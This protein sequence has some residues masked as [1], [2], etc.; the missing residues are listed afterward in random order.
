MMEKILI[1]GAKGFFGTRFCKHYQG[2]YEI[3]GTDKDDTDITDEKAVSQLISQIK[4][5]YI[6]HTAAVP[7]TNF[8]NENPQLAHKINVEGA[9]NV[10]KAAKVAHAKMVLLSTEQIFNGNPEKGPYKET[11]VPQPD[12]VYGQN[13]VEAE[14]KLKEIIDELW[15]LRFTWL[16]GLP[17]RRCS[18]NPNILWNAVQIALK[19]KPAQITDNEF[20]GY[21]YVYDVIDQFEKLFSLPYDTYH[22]GSRNDLSRYDI[23][24]HIFRELGLESRISD[25]LV[26][27]HGAYRDDRLDT[28][29]IQSLG[30]H[31]DESADSLNKCIQEFYYR[32]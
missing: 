30:F 19:G 27:T 31:F 21:T 24:C 13:K 14:A 11:D 32:Q 17:E 6:I 25:L 28:G 4:P 26:K 2:K 15:V 22:V 20:R 23:T 18:M 16:Y 3:Y 7:V 29:K 12:T 8:C 5:A 1:T 9:L 10:A